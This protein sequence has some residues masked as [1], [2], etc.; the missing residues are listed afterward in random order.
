[1]HTFA[2]SLD[3]DVSL[4]IRHFLAFLANRKIAKPVVNQCEL[5]YVNHIELPQD[6]QDFS[7]LAKIFPSMTVGNP[8]GFL[9]TPEVVNWTIRYKLPNERGRLHVQMDPGFRPTDFHLIL[10]LTLTARGA[11]EGTSQAE[12]M[13]WFDLAHEWIVRG[14]DEV[15]GPEMHK[16]WRKRL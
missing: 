1:M 7:I 3:N 11:P 9:P 15:T 4:V 2:F 14:F 10:V 12:I 6:T 13:A 16:K 5:T 8:G